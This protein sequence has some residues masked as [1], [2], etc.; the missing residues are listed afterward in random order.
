MKKIKLF[1]AGI[2]ILCCG[3][4]NGLSQTN[5]TSGTNANPTDAGTYNTAL[6]Y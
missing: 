1:F 6:G 4:I 5:T 2:I 3:L